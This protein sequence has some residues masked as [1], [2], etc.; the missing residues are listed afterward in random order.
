[1]KFFTKKVQEKKKVDPRSQKFVDAIQGMLK[2]QGIT[3]KR[4][5]NE[6]S[7]KLL[8]ATFN[9]FKNLSPGEDYSVDEVEGLEKKFRWIMSVYGIKEEDKQDEIF[10]KFFGTLN[11]LGAGGLKE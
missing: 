11:E 8:K 9:F 3:D 7:H 6:C 4:A 1:M 10:I 2:E 5:L